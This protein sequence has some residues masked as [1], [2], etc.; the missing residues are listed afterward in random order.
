M[1]QPGWRLVIV[2]AGWPARARVPARRSASGSRY[3][4]GMCWTSSAASAA[5]IPAAV[6]NSGRAEDPRGTGTAWVAV[7]NRDLATPIT[8]MPDSACACAPRPGRPAGSRS[9]YCLGC[10]DAVSWACGLGGR[11]AVAS[12]GRPARSVRRRDACGQDVTSADQRLARRGSRNPG[13]SGSALEFVISDLSGTSV[14]P[15]VT[16]RWTIAVIPGRRRSL[17][18]GTAV[19]YLDSPASCPDAPLRRAQGGAAAAAVMRS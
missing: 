16:A 8:G 15:P 1:G 17:S 6:T 4:P 14:A 2:A 3:R 13:R 11:Q 19:H 10:Q 12:C 5:G 7:R 18:A 9:A